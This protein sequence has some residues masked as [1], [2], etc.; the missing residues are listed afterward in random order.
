MLVY[1]IYSSYIYKTM[2]RSWMAS[3]SVFSDKTVLTYMN[4]RL[5]RDFRENAGLDDVSQKNLEVN[6]HDGLCVFSD[7]GLDCFVRIEVIRN[8]CRGSSCA[9]GS[10]EKE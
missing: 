10:I 6:F 4:D 9:K 5:G 2:V 3:Q 8:D 1:S 7:F